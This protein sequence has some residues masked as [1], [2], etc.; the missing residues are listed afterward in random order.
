LQAT[1]HSK[2]D[3]K[4]L[5]KQPRIKYAFI[6]N[7]RDEFSV[8]SMYRVLKL[9]R[10]GFYTWFNQ[11]LSKRAIEDQRLLKLIKELYL[12]S[13]LPI[14]ALVFIVIFLMRA[15]IAV[16]QH[17]KIMR[18]N[19]LRAQIGYKRRYIKWRNKGKFTEN[20][21]DR[22]FSTDAPNQTWVSD[23][24]YVKTREEF[25]YMRTVLDLFSRKV[26]GWS[27][28]KTMDRY[29]VIKAL[30]MAIWQTQPK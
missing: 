19:T 9:H 12:T 4:I 10:S 21:L 8:V 17:C 13:G 11:P 27:M 16:S 18:I 20:I 7:H 15:S 24:T 25:L 23:I 29:L 28:D 1:R 22:K 3:L 26:V 5:C 6:R 30:L 2:K 14:E